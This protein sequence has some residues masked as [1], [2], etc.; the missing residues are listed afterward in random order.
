MTY[1][2]RIG[3]AAWRGG[4]PLEKVVVVVV[5]TVVVVLIVFVGVFHP[6]RVLV[7]TLPRGLP[8]VSM[9]RGNMGCSGKRLWQ[10]WRVRKVPPVKIFLL[11]NSLLVNSM[12]V[13]SLLLIIFLKTKIID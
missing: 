9:L 4:I 6:T 3:G 12:L 11:S 13:N 1:S 8:S 7:Y 2:Y 10:Q 5:V